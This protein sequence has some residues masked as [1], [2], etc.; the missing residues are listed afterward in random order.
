[1]LVDSKRGR[2]GDIVEHM[3]ETV[4]AERLDLAAVAADEVMVVIA[5]RLRRL[6]VGAAGAQLEPV[7]E[8]QLRE[9]LE[10]AVDARDADARTTHPHEVVNLLHGEAALL[11]SERVDHR[12]ARPARL[13]A[14]LTKKRLR[15]L[16]PPH[17]PE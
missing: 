8:P 9:R 12:R 13:E 16:G 6:V 17:S 1:M 2:S 11:L 4:V 3:L 15:M 10:R 5:A 7:N 14:G